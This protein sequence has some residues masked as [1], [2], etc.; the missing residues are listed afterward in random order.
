MPYADIPCLIDKTHQFTSIINE[1]INSN[2]TF[3]NFMIIST[4]LFVDFFAVTILYIWI[5]KTRS[6]RIMIVFLL[7]Y[8]IRGIHLYFFRL[9]FPAGFYFPY[10]GFPSLTVPYGRESDFFFSGHCGMLTICMKELSKEK[11]NTLKIINLFAIIWTAFSL[12]CLRVHYF[13][14]ISTGILWATFLF[15][16]IDSKEK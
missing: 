12:V 8:V 2:K 10:P 15:N 5:T 6:I 11:F 4:S 14:D 13:I 7:F 9:K 1:E 3:G 16:L